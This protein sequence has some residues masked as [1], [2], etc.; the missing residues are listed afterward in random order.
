MRLNNNKISGSGARTSAL[1]DAVPRDGK[2]DSLITERVSRLMR[3]SALRMQ[4]PD[5]FFQSAVLTLRP[6]NLDL[7]VQF[8]TQ[9]Q[10]QSRAM[11][12]GT[13]DHILSAE[14]KY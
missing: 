7:D 13:H 10:E 12:Q 8:P 14:M 9:E 5:T 6:A 11:S 1:P 4:L 3:T 2:L